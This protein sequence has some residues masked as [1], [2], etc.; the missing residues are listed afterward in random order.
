M[1]VILFTDRKNWGPIPFKVFD[2][3]MKL[4]EV[5]SI[6]PKM[7]KEESYKSWMGIMKDIKVELKTWSRVK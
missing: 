6:L 3:L 5:Q 1:P 2:D 4:E 7:V